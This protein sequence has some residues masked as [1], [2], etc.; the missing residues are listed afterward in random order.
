MK[1][2]GIHVRGVKLDGFPRVLLYDFLLVAHI[3]Q[4]LLDQFEA[5]LFDQNLNDSVLVLM[6]SFFQDNTDDVIDLVDN[7]ILKRFFSLM[8]A[9]FEVIDDLGV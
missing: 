1:L 8:V 3:H 2:S 9:L 7:F 5:L 6:T 4:L